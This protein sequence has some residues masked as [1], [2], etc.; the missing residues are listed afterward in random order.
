MYRCPLCHQSLVLQGRSWQCQSNH[1]FDVA[2]EGYV[3]LL[4]V[5]HKRSKQ[6]G[7]NQAMMQARRAFLEAGHYAPLAKTLVSLIQSR[8][9]ATCSLLDFGCGEGYY[10]QF[11]A[12]HLIHAECW[13]MDISKVAI[14][15]AAKRDK[16]I[17][18]S[19]ASAYDLPFETES[20]DVL[21]RIYAPSKLDE[22]VRVLKPGGYFIS[23]EPAANHLIELKQ[24]IYAD[25]RT[26]AMED[27]ILDGLALQTQQRLSYPLA[28]TVAQD[29]LNL[30]NM[31]PFSWKVQSFSESELL[32]RLPQM[33][34][35]FLIRVFQKPIT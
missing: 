13:G 35:D 8:F 25:P 31:T 1:H 33:S 3:N 16:K 7:D 26:H 29:C 12:T 21:T 11:F 4:P 24:A 20:F 28:F 15:Y 30:I 5:Q 10:T 19:V 9:P 6:P 23:V 18:F 2:K 14:R 32:D 22:V 17:R 34:I 27:A